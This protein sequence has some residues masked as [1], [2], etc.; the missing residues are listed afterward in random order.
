MKKTREIFYNVTKL[1]KKWENYFDIYDKHLMPYLE[2]NPTILE[3]GIAHGGS[4]EMFKEYFENCTIYGVDYNPECVDVV[5]NLGVHVTI[6]NQGDPKFW[7]DFLIDKPEFD[8]IID[9]GGHEMNQQLI[10]LLKTYPKLKNNGIY[11]VEDTHTSYWNKW[12]G[13]FRNPDSFIEFTKNLVD[14]LH[15]PHIYDKQPPKEFLEIFKN[16]WSISYY[17]SIV[18]FEKRESLKS[19]EAN[20]N[21][22]T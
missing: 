20:N 3:I 4:T 5:K 15:Y 18:I 16:F 1:S 6:G 19:I 2:K 14:F 22:T 7:D 9:D 10:T 21:K 8:I 17:N 12:G 11:V 13:G